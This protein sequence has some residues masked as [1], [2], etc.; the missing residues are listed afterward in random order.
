MI[1]VKDHYVKFELAGYIF[2][3]D[4][5]VVLPT[6]LRYQVVKYIV[7]R[8]LDVGVLY[9]Y[10]MQYQ[11]DPESPFFN[12][13]EGGEDV[14]DL[15]KL[16]KLLIMQLSR[17]EKNVYLDRDAVKDIKERKEAML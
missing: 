16:M 7:T 9:G 15:L 8:M 13:D 14:V 5:Y 2:R 1:N 12:E 6:Y 4:S 11:V 17:G 10:K 3:S